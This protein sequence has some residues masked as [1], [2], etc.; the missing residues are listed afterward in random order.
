MQEN[1]RT[2]ETMESWDQMTRWPCEKVHKHDAAV[3]QAQVGNQW[4]IFRTT[5]SGS[6]TILGRQHLELGQAAF[7][8]MFMTIIGRPLTNQKV[9]LQK[10][11]NCGCRKGFFFLRTRST[12]LRSERGGAD[13]HSHPEH[14]S[15]TI[16]SQQH[17]SHS[18]SD[19]HIA[20][21]FFSLCCLR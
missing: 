1:S 21:P 12:I 8:S 2:C 18:L 3:R 13:E 19:V 7:A 20:L 4:Y 14:T 9:L 10:H 16:C 17:A 6:N 5:A 15:R 11:H